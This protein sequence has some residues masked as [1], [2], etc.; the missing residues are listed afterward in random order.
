MSLSYLAQP[1][2]AC[3]VHAEWGNLGPSE[4]LKPVGKPSFFLSDIV[5]SLNFV[6]T[7]FHILTV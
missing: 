3:D 4:K 1:S 2:A 7:V 5:H 6:L